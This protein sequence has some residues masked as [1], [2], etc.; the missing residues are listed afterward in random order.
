MS[1][2]DSINP[3]DFKTR[4]SEFEDSFR[5]KL[6]ECEL[7][8]HIVLDFPVYKIL[9][10]EVSLALKILQRHQS[11]FKLEYVDKAKVGGK[12]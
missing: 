1:N 6:K 3:Q 8:M 12:E 10:D 4:V 2:T 11:S 5:K 9:P 7:D